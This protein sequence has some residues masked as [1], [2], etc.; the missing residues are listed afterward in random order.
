VLP[1]LIET[2][3]DGAGLAGLGRDGHGHLVQHLLQHNHSPEC[4]EVQDSPSRRKGSA[5][6]VRAGHSRSAAWLARPPV[7]SAVASSGCLQALYKLS[8]ARSFSVLQTDGVQYRTVAALALSQQHGT[9][10]RRIQRVREAVAVVSSPA[11]IR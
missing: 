5:R 2:H 11:R 8:T 6:S 9:V 7:R 4:S 3:R 10:N 1:S